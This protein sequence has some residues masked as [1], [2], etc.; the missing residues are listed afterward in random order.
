VTRA[1]DNDHGDRLVFAIG[2]FKL[3]KATLILLIVTGG[4]VLVE[5]DPA[6][7]LARRA[8]WLHVDTTDGKSLLWIGAVSYAYAAVFC[9][10][11]VGLIK[12]RRWAEWLTIFV[13]ASFLPLEVYEVFHRT[14]PP[15]VATL[16]VN[17]L[18]VGYLVWRRVA[19]DREVVLTRPS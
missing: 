9:V 13:T 8:H 1:R 11:G 15:R 3:V 16:V 5:K 18:I 10:E 7:W 17:V 14:S 2:V 4:I 6:G 12:R 19:Q